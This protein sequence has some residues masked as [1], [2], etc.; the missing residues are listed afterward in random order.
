MNISNPFG[1]YEGI[2][3]VYHNGQWGTVC[4]TR[5]TYQD[6]LLA[7]LTAGFQSAVRPVTDGSL[8]RGS[9]TVQLGYVECAGSEATLFDCPKSSWVP[10]NC[11][12]HTQDVAVV[13]SDGR[14]CIQTCTYTFIHTHT[15]THTD[16]AVRLVGGNSESEGRVEVYHSS[17]WGTVCDD[18]WTMADA[19]V[20][21]KQLGFPAALEA[22]QRS[23]SQFGLAVSQQQIW[24]D[25]VRCNGNETQLAECSFRGWGIHNCAHYEDAGVRCTSGEGLK[26]FLYCWF[27][28]DILNYANYSY[29]HTYSWRTHA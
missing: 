13:C 10:G 19:Q 25:D 23:Y 24:M 28:L 16:V 8:G 20:V 12:D 7:C 11:T 18:F 3:E 5:W 22:V 21:C 6:A 1:Q 14:F 17:Q 15:H 29:H 27:K 9:G 2:V 4:D 26:V